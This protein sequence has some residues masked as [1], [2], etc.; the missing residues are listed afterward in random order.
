MKRT[1]LQSFLKLVDLE[2][3]SRG[4]PLSIQD[5]PDQDFFAFFD[6]DQDEDEAKAAAAELVDEMIFV[7]EL[8]DLESF[9]FVVEDENGA[10]V[11]LNEDEDEANN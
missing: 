6:E 2:L 3:E 8:P 7:G 10:T 11:Y 4:Y 5:L 1:S 9:G